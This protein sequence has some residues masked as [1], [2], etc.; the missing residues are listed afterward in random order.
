[1]DKNLILETKDLTVNFGGLLATNKVNIQVPEGKI[2]GVIGPNGAGK[3]T[4]FNLITGAIKATEG[5]V[6][7]NCAPIKPIEQG[8][9]APKRTKKKIARIGEKIKTYSG[10][11]QK[12]ESLSAQ[13]Q[14]VKDTDK[15]NAEKLQKRYKREYEQALTKHTREIERLGQKGDV[16]NLVGKRTDQVARLGLSRTF[17][18]IRLYNRMTVLENV[19]ISLQRIPPY[20][21]GTALLGLPEKFRRDAFDRE[22]AMGYLEMLGIADFAD[23]PAGSLPYGKQR[24]LE[25]ARAIATRPRLLLLDEPAAGMNNEE[26]SELVGLIKNI[27]EKLGLTILLIEHHMDVVMQ[28]SDEIYVINLGEVLRH[29]EPDQI[30]SDPEVIKAY[31]GERRRGK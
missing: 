29:G 26:C 1:M 23:S 16:I 4:I 21:I 31:L 22:L 9:V 13:L 12:L 25:I 15:K 11:E 19:V 14:K 27:H 18:N 3:T 5:Q 2:V 24:R 30:Q 20:A 7:Y 10:D 8:Y 17:Q 6:L 28:L